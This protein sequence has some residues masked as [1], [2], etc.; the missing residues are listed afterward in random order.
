M[1]CLANLREFAS[2]YKHHPGDL[3]MRNL[4]AYAYKHHPGEKPGSNEFRQLPTTFRS[5]N[6]QVDMMTTISIS[7]YSLYRPTSSQLVGFR[8]SVDDDDLEVGWSPQARVRNGI[9]AGI[10]CVNVGCLFLMNSHTK[11]FQRC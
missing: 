11:G 4:V 7:Q 1:N 10:M 2:A 9:I 5:A 3:R 6:P 8:F